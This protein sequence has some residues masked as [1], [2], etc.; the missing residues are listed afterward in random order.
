MLDYQNP[1]ERPALPD[2]DGPLVPGIVEEPA[3]PDYGPLVTYSRH[4]LRVL[5]RAP[6]TPERSRLVPVPFDQIQITTNPPYL[7]KE[8]IPR[9][10]LS[11]AWGPPKCGKSFWAFDLMM[12]VALGWEYRGRRIT[13]GPVVYVACEGAHGFRARIEAF[14]QRHLAEQAEGIPFFLIPA[15]IDLVGEVHE[16]IAAINTVMAETKPIA[17]VLDTLNR[18]MRGSESSDEDMSAY[19]K[20]ADVVRETFGC[21]VLIVHH[22]GHEATR[23]RGHTSLTGAA[24]AQIAVKRDTAGT[25]TATVEWLKDGAEGQEEFSRLESVEIG[26]DDDGEPITSCVV[27]PAEK[28]ETEAGPRLGGKAKIALDHLE[29]AIED[30]GEL[31]PA[32]NHIPRTKRVVRKALWRGYCEKGSLTDSDKPDSQTKAFN[33]A[34]EKLQELGIIGVWND[35]VWVARTKQT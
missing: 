11:V 17:V 31:P 24:D 18:S 7:V 19:I 9:E 22:C 28:S 15:T 33:R 26:I 13:Q 23:P 8:F 5:D 34:A 2:R 20:A 4:G 32:S 21:A 14:R 30:A 25:I 29:R 12:H 10:G 6:A 27:V 1:D 16:L 35:F 3:P